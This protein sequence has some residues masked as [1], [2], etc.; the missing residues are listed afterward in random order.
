M[1]K[2]IM[3]HVLDMTVNGKPYRR[4]VDSRILL[5][6]FLRD[7]LELTGTHIGCVVG[8]CGA[9]TVLLS[10]VAIKSCT[11]FA[12]QAQD[13]DISTIEGLATDGQLHPIQQAFQEYHALQCGYCTPGMLLAAYDL[14]QNNPDP[15]EEEI[16]EGI[17]GNLCMCTGYV[18][19]VRSV[20]AAAEKMP[21]PKKAK[22]RA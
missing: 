6:D 10:G 3:K 18:D 13:S 5:V 12:V 4:E 16:R 14:L 19:I 22:S 1:N 2:F 8:K 21:R 7:Y 15:S 9:C 17:S 20:K 11:V